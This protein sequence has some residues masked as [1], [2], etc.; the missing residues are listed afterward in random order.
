MIQ[1]LEIATD[2]N[3]L[4]WN[5]KLNLTT[6]PKFESVAVEVCKSTITEYSMSPPRCSPQQNETSRAG[7]TTLVLQ[8]KECAEEERGKGY[9]V[10]CLV[11]HRGNIT[12]HQCHQYITK[13]TT[14]IF[15]DYR[16]I[17]GFMDKCREDINALHCGS[18]SAGEKVRSTPPS[19]GTSADPSLCARLLLSDAV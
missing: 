9:L 17:C 7:I 12:E 4:L 2:C 1:E 3:H 8:I 14:I 5:Y 13:M 6:D 16:L 18:I 11:D 19:S 10:S 15:S